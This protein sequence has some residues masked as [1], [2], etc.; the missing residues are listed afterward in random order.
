MKNF[1][2]DLN[3]GKGK[4]VLVYRVKSAIQGI[5]TETLIRSANNV[6]LDDAFLNTV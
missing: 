1:T 4:L 5:C 3:V 2:A 6:T